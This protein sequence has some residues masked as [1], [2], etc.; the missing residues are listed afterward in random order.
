VEVFDRNVANREKQV[1]SSI[2]TVMLDDSYQHMKPER[3]DMA[4]LVAGDGDYV[5]AVRSLQRRGLKVRVVFWRHAASRELRETADEFNELDPHFS[6]LT[7][8]AA[9]H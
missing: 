9:R 3:G 6:R 2:V 8:S 4:I 5:P 7:L 1:D